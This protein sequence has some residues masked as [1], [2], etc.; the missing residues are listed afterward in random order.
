MS[1]SVFWEMTPKAEL[2][3]TRFV[4]TVMNSCAK[5]AYEHAQMIIENPNKEFT[6]LDFPQLYNG[7]DTK[8]I[9]TTINVLQ[10]LAIILRE[11]RF[12]NGALRIDNLKLCF[13]LNSETG[14]PL[15]YSVYQS[16]D[17][18]RLI[19]E[20]MLLANISVA[21]KINESFP[22][23]AFLRCHQPPKENMLVNLQNKLAMYGIHLNISSAGEIQASLKKYHTEDY[24]GKIL[25]KDA[26]NST[27]LSNAPGHALHILALQAKP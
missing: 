22:E 15:D 21:Q 16:Q 26:F 20:F 12:K 7:F 23:L 19:E 1:F 5:L 4:R 11:N 27:Y 10:S 25:L 14:D 18:H 3:N 8:D 9:V 13:E 24:P 6:S 17:S 2:L